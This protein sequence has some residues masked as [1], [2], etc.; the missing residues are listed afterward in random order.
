MSRFSVWFKNDFKAVDFVKA[1][2]HKDSSTFTVFTRVGEKIVEHV[3]GA[4][5]NQRTLAKDYNKLYKAMSKVPD[6]E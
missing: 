3:F 2:Y 5:E 1:D 6:E 4:Y